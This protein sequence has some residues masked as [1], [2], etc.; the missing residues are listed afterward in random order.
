MRSFRRQGGLAAAA[1][2][3][4]IVLA[5]IALVAGRGFFDKAAILGQRDVTEAHFKAVSDALVAFATLN[6]R[7]PCPA[8]GDLDTGDADPTTAAATCNST[9]GV[10]PWKTLALRREDAL[11][12]WG[13]K[14]S[15]RVFSGAT[16]FTQADGMSM[17]N[18]N[19]S[20]GAAIN[21]SL[22]SGSLCQS[23]S[24]PPNT[25]TQFLA[26]RGNMLV[27]QDLGTTRS[28]N[29]FVLISHGESG[30]GAY[31]AEGAVARTTLPDSSGKEYVNTQATDT[32]WILARSSSGTLVTDAGYFDDMV[33]YKSASD[34]VASAKLGARSWS[35]IPLA[36]T[37]DSSTVQ[38]AA[39]GFNAGTSQDTGYSSLGLGGFLVSA[40][41]SG[42]T[43]DIGF[44][45]QGGIG[46]IGVIG[47]GSTSGDLNS[48]FGESLTFQLGYASEFGKVDV[49]LN[50]F[51]VVDNSPL[52]KERAQVSLYDSGSLVQK[53]I[54]DS[55]DYSGNPTNCLFRAV[56]GGVFDRMDIAPLT[57]TGGSGS[58]RFTV[59]AIT[60]CTDVT[61][62]C[63]TA[64]S[65]AVACPIPPP[66]A[67]SNAPSSTDK[68]TATLSG[69]VQDNSVA[70][71]S[72][73][74]Y[75]TSSTFSGYP[76][77]RTRLT[78]TT[79]SGTILAGNCLT[80]ASDANTYVV[81]TGTA[82]PGDIY[83]ADPGLL[84]A[85]PSFTA[86]NVTLTNCQTAV[87]FDYGTSC[88]YGSSATASPATINAGAG[89]TSV[90]ASITGL[91]CSTTYYFRTK[92]TS[93][94]GTTTGN[95]R[96]FTTS[97]C[98]ST[99]PGAVT[100]DPIS[101][102]TTTA[103]MYGIVDDKGMNTTVTF[104]Y[105][106]TSCYGSSMAATPGTMTAGTGSTA[107]IANLTGL[108]CNTYYHYRVKAVS[109]GG[110]STGSDTVF[111]TS[112]C[113]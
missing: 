51:Q 47:G 55:W 81:A 19:S 27:V 48:S 97:A 25:P 1:V 17:T 84:V 61:S 70:K 52:R 69:T 35:E 42:V 64:V 72:G 41:A 79:G 102:G 85:I 46:G 26:A 7:L 2:F 21:N 32:Y 38:A 111:L 15:Y 109:S 11:D 37:L 3:I 74:N 60:A 77:G 6:R 110:T 86:R 44:V 104:D 29:A 20:L 105:G 36:T 58:T 76:V 83:I 10:V 24:P 9:A 22:G 93:A 101:T 4:I 75:R 57:D 56:S 63:A 113:P 59:S 66:S 14:I 98:A 67:A 78:L 28:G 31:P 73:T 106:L 80:I 88:A 108:T 90:T 43:Q 30:Y 89:S 103:T 40:S 13:R 16:G 107:V 65:G 87:T 95:D 8:R 23:G 71:G 45:V 91:A 54:V 99:A 92:A 33:A 50:Q 68:T 112:A 34:L 62:P 100:H 82:A 12:G 96:L 18:C 49:A 94:G 5:V 39:P 53:S